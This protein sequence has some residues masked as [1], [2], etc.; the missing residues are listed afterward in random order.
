MP[1]QLLRVVWRTIHAIYSVC[2]RHN[3]EIRVEDLQNH[4]EIRQHGTGRF[5]FRVRPA[6][7]NLIYGLD[8]GEDKG[9]T[10][11]YLFV[12]FLGLSFRTFF[13]LSRVILLPFILTRSISGGLELQRWRA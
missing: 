4:Y 13:W 2:A 11:K 1:F 3:F 10:N 9:W 7:A 6:K 8:T 5:H 12:L